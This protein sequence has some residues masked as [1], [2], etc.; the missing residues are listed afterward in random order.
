[1]ICSEVNLASTPRNTR[2][3][4]FGATTHIS[5]SIHG[6]LNYRAPND[7]EIFIY[8]GDGKLVEV[9]VIGN[10]RLLL[11]TGI[12]LDLKET[13]I[14]LSFRR[15]LVSISVLDKL[16]YAR[17][18]RNSQFSLYLNSIFLVLILFWDLTIFICSI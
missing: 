13:F 7:A 17:S 16:G 18:F 12:Y 1:M 9:E 14:V 10:F 6:C 5:V 3:I 2:W 4:D 11:K 15:N 8:V